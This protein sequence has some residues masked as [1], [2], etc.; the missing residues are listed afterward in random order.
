MV[1]ADEVGAAAA[2]ND[3]PS[4]RGRVTR[5]LVLVVL[6]LAAVAAA[7]VGLLLTIGPLAPGGHGGEEVSEPSTEVVAEGLD[8]ATSEIHA[9]LNWLIWGPADARIHPEFPRLVDATIEQ[10]QE[11]GEQEIAELL[12]GARDAAV[13]DDELLDAHGLAEDAETLA[14]G[15]DVERDESDVDVPDPDTADGTD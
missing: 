2:T 4:R 12:R 9:H 6:A 15:G 8:V 10:A 11:E 5:R 7:V 3:E 14:H 13:R 1:E